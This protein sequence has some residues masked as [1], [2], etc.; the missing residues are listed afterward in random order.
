M[1]FTS[2]ATSRAQTILDELTVT[3][4]KAPPVTKASLKEFCL[5]LIIDADLV[6]LSPYFQDIIKL[7]FS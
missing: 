5:E 2:Y 4:K 6:S 7:S 1:I 3:I